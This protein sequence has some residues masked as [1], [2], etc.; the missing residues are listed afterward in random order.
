MITPQRLILFGLVSLSFVLSFGFAP[1]ILT[2]VDHREAKDVLS[3]LFIVLT[4]GMYF[5]CH[6]KITQV[7]IPL[8]LLTGYCVMRCFLTPQ[9]SFP[10]LN[11]DE[12]SIWQYRALAYVLL[13]FIFYIAVSNMCWCSRI[14]RQLF[15]TI[16][17]VGFLVSLYC[18]VQWFNLDQWQTLL[19]REDLLHTPS[20]RV[21]GTMTHVTLAAAFLVMT[22]PFMI[23][24]RKWLFLLPTIVAIYLCHSDV[25]YVALA[26]TVSFYG[27]FRNRLTRILTL[28]ILITGL[29]FLWS[30]SDQIKIN[31]SG[32][33]AIWKQVWTDVCHS[34]FEKG[35]SYFLTGYG[36]GSYRYIFTALHTTTV[37]GKVKKIAFNKAHNE[38]VEWFYNTAFIGEALLLIFIF[39]LIIQAI[40]YTITDERYLALLSAVIASCICAGGTFVWQIEPHRFYTVVLAAI[41]QNRINQREKRV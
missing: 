1:V 10:L 14:L 19:P 22:V 5:R 31:D 9:F 30:I 40:P 7:P 20:A 41:I 24:M 27:L 38:Y 21:V 25:A 35:K 34:P 39:Y 23:Q 17:W 3:V 33:F 29:S 36:L 16:C 37:E 15:T 13:F 18:I 12:D 32:R 6:P 2:I 4:I 26:G 8:I 11:T 28:V